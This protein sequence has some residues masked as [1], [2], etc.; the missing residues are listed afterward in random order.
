M[1]VNGMRAREICLTIFHLSTGGRY[2]PAAGGKLNSF[3]RGTLPRRTHS[4]RHSA[5]GQRVQDPPRCSDLL[6]FPPTLLSEKRHNKKNRFTA[7]DRPQLVPASVGYCLFGNPERCNTDW[8]V[9]PRIA[10]FSPTVSDRQLAQPPCPVI[11]EPEDHAPPALV[12]PRRLL[13]ERGCVSR[14]TFARQAFPDCRGYL[15]PA[16][17]RSVSPLARHCRHPIRQYQTSLGK[18]RGHTPG[19]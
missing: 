10:L 1:G 16:R 9:L 12:Q 3:A 7:V 17:S 19:T 11:C 13:R 14:L 4:F 15:V 18:G 5:S 6:F 2:A 8:M